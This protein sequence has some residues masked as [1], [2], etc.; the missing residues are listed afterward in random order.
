MNKF[1]TFEEFYDDEPS[2]KSEIEVIEPSEFAVAIDDPVCQVLKN[3]RKLLSAVLKN[4]A[5]NALS[6]M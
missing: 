4:F 6:S 1:K 5:A 2:E 3:D